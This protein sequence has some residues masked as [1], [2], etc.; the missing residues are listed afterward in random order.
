M[1]AVN[2]QDGASGELVFQQEKHRVG[3]VFRA[4]DMS[5]WQALRHL[6]DHRCLLGSQDRFQERR[7]DPAR[8]DGVDTHGCE[9]NGEAVGEREEG[10]IDRGHQ[11]SRRQRALGGDA[12]GERD[13]ALLVDL[14]GSIFGKEQRRDELG[15]N[16]LACG[17]QV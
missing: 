10:A 8:R 7:V 16:R 6:L 3:D 1:A 14:P 9:R 4:S 13:G 17:V 12:S 11:K 15:I 5:D 2:V